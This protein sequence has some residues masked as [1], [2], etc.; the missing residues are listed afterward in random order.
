MALSKAV[1]KGAFEKA[2]C[3]LKPGP[4]HVDVMVHVKGDV[5]VGEDYLRTPTVAI[6]LKATLAFFIRRMGITREAAKQALIEAMTEALKEGV[7]GE[8]VILSS[9]P[10]V[11]EAMEHVNSMTA[12]LPKAPCKGPVTA[13]LSVQIVQQ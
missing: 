7:K 8:D 12:A 13:K 1:T 6:P 3:E 4:H 2:R 10:E 9:F 5:Q 11:T